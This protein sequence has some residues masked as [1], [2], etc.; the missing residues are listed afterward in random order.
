MLWVMC[1]GYWSIKYLKA[2]TFAFDI[3][4]ST[5]IWA[6]HKNVLRGKSLGFRCIQKYMIYVAMDVLYI[7]CGSKQ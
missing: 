1:L 4:F 6:S 7:F 3:Y 2:P 5:S